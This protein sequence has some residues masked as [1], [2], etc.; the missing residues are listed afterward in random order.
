MSD[1][2]ELLACPIC[3]KQPNLTERGSAGYSCHGAEPPHRV[4]S[5]GAT[6][7]EARAAWNT[8][9]TPALPEERE[10]LVENLRS[11]EA[12]IRSEVAQ[13]RENGWNA[14]A[15]MRE[16]RADELAA[17]ITY[18]QIAPVPIASL[19]DE[20]RQ[21]LGYFMRA[22]EGIAAD[23]FDGIEERYS[24]LLQEGSNRAQRV[25]GDDAP[26]LSDPL[27]D[28]EAVELV[29]RNI[30]AL[31]IAKAARRDSPDYE[32]D[33]RQCAEHVV[34]LASI[35]STEGLREAL[36]NL[37]AAVES[38][39]GSGSPDEPTM[40]Q[41]LIEAKAALRASPKG[42][43]DPTVT[44]NVKVAPGYVAVPI[45]PKPE[46]LAAWYRQKNTGSQE[47]G[48]YG[49]DCSDVDAYRAMLAASPYPSGGI[50]R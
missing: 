12:V 24:L 21:A 39:A 26:R 16:R 2:N 31:L 18:I 42:M 3:G 40:T 14:S 32:A 33:L 4:W 34:R 41:R 7:P 46:M 19:P 9:P 43:T 15:D 8:R 37:V 25:L 10:K 50:D 45:E 28:E 1:E 29:R 5:Y 35:P 36:E 6:E 44:E 47:P 17:T 38:R 22:Y 48:V 20:A 49:P 23:S 27:P 11:F 13:D 30:E